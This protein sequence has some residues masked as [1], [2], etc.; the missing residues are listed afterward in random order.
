MDMIKAASSEFQKP[1]K[2]IPLTIRSASMMV[3]AF[4][5]KLKMLKVIMV[6]GKVNSSSSGFTRRFTINKTN[7]ISSKDGI[8]RII[9]V[10]IAIDSRN[11]VA[12][13]DK[14]FNRSFDIV[15]ST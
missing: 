6:I 13:D 9:I 8:S 5:T 7:P 1:F 4:T 3:H 15:P 14:Y 11:M 12:T 2:L 10:L